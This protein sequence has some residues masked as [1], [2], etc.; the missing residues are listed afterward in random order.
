MIKIN[1]RTL[2]IVPH[3]CIVKLQAVYDNLKSAE[4]KAADLLLEKPDFFA[5][6]T[7]GEAAY[8]AGCSEATLVRLSK[9]LGY[10]GY[11]E[12]KSALTENRED[13]PAHLYKGV[14]E[15]DD[16]GEVVNKVFKASIQ[17]LEDTLNILN[18]N[19]YQKA[20]DSVCAANKIVFCGAG[21][22]SNVARSAYLKFIRTG[23]NV[24]TSDDFDVQLAAASNLHKG[25]VLIA[26]SHTGRTKSI[27]NVVKCA[28][29]FEATI[30]GITNY[31]MS[32][33][34]KNADIVLLTAVFTG[35]V[36]GEVMSKRLAELCIL[37]SMYVNVL[38]KKGGN[39]S[40]NLERSNLALEANKL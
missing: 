15:G 14:V 40:E 38:L 12:L 3:S 29:A 13:N 20:V 8:A 36:N 9:K 7:I 25:D 30:I 35:H 33:L 19:E 1:D 39:L 28:K 37:E 16:Y 27:L 31:P 10:G 34:A 18:I 32:P 6:A 5:G 24:Q 2:K 22:A 17:A 23:V 4:K 26:I 21:D 11:P